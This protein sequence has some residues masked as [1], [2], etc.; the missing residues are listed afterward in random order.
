LLLKKL[1]KSCSTPAC[2]SIIYIGALLVDV[3]DDD[4][5]VVW[6]SHTAR[7]RSA[8]CSRATWWCLARWCPARCSGNLGVG[9]VA[10]CCAT[11]SCIASDPRDESNQELQTMSDFIFF[12]RGEYWPHLLA[13]ACVQARPWG[14]SSGAAAPG[15]RNLGAPSQ[16]MCAHQKN[17]RRAPLAYAQELPLC[18][19]EE[20]ERRTLSLGFWA[21]QS[22]PLAN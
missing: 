8:Q 18:L 17:R 11:C 1:M 3:L 7:C 14:G 2:M 9:V 21:S 5:G 22:F 16:G 10:Q 4:L 12:S 13:H 19:D 15:P 6:H 20:E